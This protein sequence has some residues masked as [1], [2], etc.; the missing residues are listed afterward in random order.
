MA[1]GEVV[2]V[3][4]DDLTLRELYAER[5]KQE[6]YVVIESDNGDDAVKKALDQL[7]SLIILDI[8]M[9][10][11][12]GIDVMK[13]LRADEKTKGIPI[14][15]LTALIQ[16]VDKVKSLMTDKDAYLIKSEQMPKDVIDR[17]N[18]SLAKGSSTATGQSDN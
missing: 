14:V 6:G 9:P 4:D 18:V 1:D 8:M 12:N 11:T 13:K 5:L 17:V 7:P 2:L 16:E 3:V 15:I 10:K